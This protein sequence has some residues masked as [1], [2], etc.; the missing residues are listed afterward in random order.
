MSDNIPRTDPSDASPEPEPAKKSQQNQKFRTSRQHTKN[1]HPLVKV[2]GVFSSIWM[3]ATL[4][5][6]LIVVTG[7]ATYYE[8]DFGREI[9]AVMIYNSWWFNIIFGLLALN[10]FGAAAVRF[11][12]TQKQTGFVI[13][14][15]GLLTIMLGFAIH[16]SDRLDGMLA[17]PEGEPAK[18]IQRERE[19]LWLTSEEGVGRKNFEFEVS[20]YANYPNFLTYTLS[21]FLSPL[22]DE[23]LYPTPEVSPP[24]QRAL[25]GE[26][27]GNPVYIRRVVD[28]AEEDLSWE[29]SFEGPP[30]VKISQIR[31]GD[32][33]GVDSGIKQDFYIPRGRAL[34]MRP[35]RIQHHGE[36]IPQQLAQIYQQPIPEDLGTHGRLVIFVD[37]GD[38]KITQQF[39]PIN[40][41][42]NDPESEELI[43]Q[44]TADDAPFH[45]AVQDYIPHFDRDA[46]GNVIFPSTDPLAPVLV[47]RLGFKN[48]ETQDDPQ[49]LSPAYVD[50][51]S[52]FPQKIV[53]GLW[54]LWQ[55]PT[56]WSGYEKRPLGSSMDFLHTSDGN[57]L[58][59][60][61]SNQSGITHLEPAK[62][63]WTNQ[64][65][66]GVGSIQTTFEGNVDHV[67]EIPRML[68]MQASERGRSANWI[69]L[70]I[71]EGSQA[72]RQWVKRNS[73]QSVAMPNGNNVLL[74]Y[75][76][77]QYDL[78]D[79]HG[80]EITLKRFINEKD[81]GG[82]GNASYSSDVRVRYADGQP[83]IDSQLISMNEPFYENGVTLYQTARLEQPD[84]SFVSFFTVAQDPG[85][86]FKYLGSLIL[87]AGIL[88]MYIMKR[89]RTKKKPA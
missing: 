64:T 60:R 8:R 17:A 50:G 55:H 70:Q 48:S 56:L 46:E 80:F 29:P 89:R 27:A 84:G 62:I 5:A 54:V 14:H 82:Q 34:N 23:P 39:V 16:G 83:P 19:V 20:N 35:M 15:A 76:S 77:E 3:A 40:I 33:F 53:K 59:I 87:V 86:P 4:L 7:V 57:M 63:G 2:L 85:R 79:R 73:A 71:G 31:T 47:F 65:Q 69:E 26:F 43:I 75:G 18:I 51:L 66:M 30:A 28:T 21:L 45:V 9:S 36:A 10:I 78:L 68:K 32:I 22:L 72:T 25:L 24:G 11:P 52:F 74:T 81:P 49:W 67:S 61:A 13:T 1:R 42:E 44:K 38:G 58:L 12:W 6:V 37:H 88:T 41:S